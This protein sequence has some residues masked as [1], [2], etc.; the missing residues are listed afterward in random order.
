MLCYLGVLCNTEVLCWC[1]S[2]PCIVLV[3]WC[4]LFFFWYYI[5]VIRNGQVFYKSTV[6]DSNFLAQFLLSWYTY[7]PFCFIVLHVS[8]LLIFDGFFGAFTLCFKSVIL[9]HL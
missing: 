9:A 7:V 8:D 4:D 6:G 5:D 1:D 2:V 3:S